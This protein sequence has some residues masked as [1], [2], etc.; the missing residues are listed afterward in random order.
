MQALILAGGEGT[1]LRPLTVNTPKPI[2][3][4][5]NLP[6]MVW[7]ILGLKSAGIEDITLSLNYQPTAIEKVIGDGSRFGVNLKYIVEPVPMG[8]HR[9]G[10]RG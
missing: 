6:F 10:H 5:G 9:A 4:I 3:P 8:A 1:R 7:Q 2:V